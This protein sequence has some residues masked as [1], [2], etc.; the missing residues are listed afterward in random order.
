[1][2]VDQRTKLIPGSESRKSP[3]S[4]YIKTLDGW[5]TI[6]VFA[7][8]FYHIRYVQLGNVNLSRLQDFGDRGVQLFFAISG[9]LICSRLLE[10]QRLHGRISLA[11]FY[12]RRLFRIQP[13]AWSFLA[14]AVFLSFVGLIHLSFAPT[15]SALLS[16]RNFYS[17]LNLKALLDD[18]YTVHFWSLSVEE[19]FYLLLPFLLVIARKRLLPVLAALSAIFFV[20]PPIAHKLGL[21]ATELAQQRTDLALRDLL[22]PALL[23]VLMT[24]EKFRT[25]MTR[26]TRHGVLLC[27]V[28]AA[29][30]VSE[31]L[32]GS[33]LTSVVTCIG[34]P[35][36]VLSTMLH[37]EQLVGCLL[38]TKPF[39][40][41]GCISY[42]IYLWQQ[43]FLL[44]MREDSALHFLQNGPWNLIATLICALL[45]YYLI[46]RPM[47]RIG[48]RLAPPATPGHMDLK[49]NTAK[50]TRSNAVSQSR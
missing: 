1:M 33:H 21:T 14:V 30:L 20:W 19:H 27:G 35:M 18:R 25:W 15:V 26:I 36:M 37:P 38:E 22:V 29:I 48:H 41:F 31:L 10:E 3:A 5:R 23:A 43:L 28:I 17:A 39:R 8:C 34:F 4:G 46:E 32:L 24:R 6:A 49:D 45:S 7:V 44:R 12:T 11:G 9:I 42:S 13:A 40:F 47:I 2:P 16:Y 50:A